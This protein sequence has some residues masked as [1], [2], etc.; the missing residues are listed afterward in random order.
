MAAVQYVVVNRGLGLLQTE[1]EGVGVGGI[2][3]EQRWTKRRKQWVK[4]RNEGNMAQ[5]EGASTPLLFCPQH[6]RGG[7]GAGVEQLRG[8]RRG[9]WGVLQERWRG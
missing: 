2:T 1:G 7:S 8:G 9:L 6:K 3:E 5:T 4:L